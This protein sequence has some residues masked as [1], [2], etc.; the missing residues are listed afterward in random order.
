MGR[1]AKARKYATVRASL[2]TA[3]FPVS[4]IQGW[5]VGGASD[6]GVRPENRTRISS[7]KVFFEIVSLSNREQREVFISRNSLILYDFRRLE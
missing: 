1:S 4:E 3:V 5:E 2:E 6:G 7:W